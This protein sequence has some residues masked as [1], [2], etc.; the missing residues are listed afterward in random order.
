MIAVDKFAAV[1][2]QSEDPVL[3]SSSPGSSLFR[4]A[5]ACGWGGIERPVPN[6]LVRFAI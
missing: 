4:N 5:K 6:D 1:D 2:A 3:S